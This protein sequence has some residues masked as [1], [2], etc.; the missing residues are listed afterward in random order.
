MTNLIL[1]IAIAA[2]ITIAVVLFIKTLGAAHDVAWGIRER[3]KPVIWL[4]ILMVWLVT[5]VV[6]LVQGV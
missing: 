2:Y 3:I 4:F 1:I 5:P 6:Y